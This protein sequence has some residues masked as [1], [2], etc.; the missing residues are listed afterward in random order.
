[1]ALG[2]IPG[3]VFDL[4]INGRLFPSFESCFDLERDVG[5]ERG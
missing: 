3:V 2:L 4:F 1:M 5:F